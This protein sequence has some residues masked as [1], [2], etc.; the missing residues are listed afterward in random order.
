MRSRILKILFILFVLLVIAT[1]T[2]QVILWTDLPQ[3]LVIETLNKELGFKITTGSLRTSLRGKTIIKDFALS[4]PM[5]DSPLL[6][7]PEMSILHTALPL[8]L[9]RRSLNLQS[10]K[11]E[12]PIVNFRE[13]ETGYWNIQEF[14]Y[15][16]QQFVAGSNKQNKVRFPQLDIV[17]GSSVIADRSGHIE[18]L[19]P[20][21]FSG[22]T[23]DQPIWDFEMTIPSQVTVSGKVDAGN[24]WAHDIEFNIKDVNDLFKN[25]IVNSPK[26]L[27][28][29]GRWRGRKHESGLIGKLQLKQLHYGSTQTQGILGIDMSSTGFLISFEDLLVRGL[30]LPIQEIKIT[31]GSA[32]LERKELQVNHLLFKTDG[33]SGNLTGQWGWKKGEGT[34]RGSWAGKITERNIYSEGTWDG[35]ISWPLMGRKE[36][37]VSVFSQGDTPWGGWHNELTILGSGST[38]SKSNWQVSVPHLSWQRKGT[39]ITF[40]DVRAEIAADWPNVRLLSIES[41]NPENLKAEGEFWVDKCTWAI[42]VEAEGWKTSERQDLTIDLRLVASG[43]KQDV[44]VKEFKLAKKDLTIEAA[45]KV[46]LSSAKLYD[47]H[48]KASWMVHQP[49]ADGK[50]LAGISGKLQ[51]EAAIAGTVWPISLQLK[52]ELLGENI[53][54][55]RNVVSTIKIPWQAQIDPARIEFNT[56]R[57]ELFDG[58]W[59]VS[60]QYELYQSS[61]KLTLDATEVSL[62]PMVKLLGLPIKS[63]GVMAVKIEAELPFIDMND[64]TLTG[65]WS[66]KD[67]VLGAI[68]A[69]NAEGDV[70]I[71]HGAAMF[72]LI[73]LK[74]DQGQVL[75][76]ARFELDQPQY[77][78]VEM[79]ARQWPLDLPDYGM[80]FVTSSKGNATLDLLRRT[81]KGNGHITAV[82][83]L[84]NKKFGDIS[85]EIAVE[86]RTIEINKIQLETL[87]GSVGATARIPVDDWL[88]S[89]ADVKWQDLDI[90][91]LSDLRAELKGLS[92]RSSGI[93]TV[94]RAEENQSLEPLRIEIRANI[95]EGNFRNAHLGDLQISGYLGKERLL[96]DRSELEIMNGVLKSRGSI[97]RHR[98]ELLSYVHADFSQLELDQ[99]IGL[100]QHHPDPVPGRLTGDGMLIVFSDLHGMTGEANV[101]LSESDLASIVIVE[102]LHDALNIRL[103]QTQP[104]GQ[105]QIRMRFEGSTVRIPSFTYFNRGIEIR[106]MGTVQDITQGKTSPVRGYV[107]GSV[108]PLK[109]THLPGMEALDRLM[110]SLQTGVSSVEVKG[111]LGEPETVSVPFHQISNKLR[112]LLWRQLS[113]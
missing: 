71:Q 94:A 92:G 2:T 16:L 106:G 23:Q 27:S 48:A 101:R 63:Q 86:E 104:T 112:T 6:L 38:L 52:S 80:T 50:N 110:A 98:K 17:N 3:R 81:T 46:A 108:R 70:C 111:T 100:F 107:I 72:D 35:F 13:D 61:A 24:T 33:I 32:L 30:E 39:D 43:N 36:I 57:F 97:K 102:T 47:A 49:P 66:V 42:S 19:G 21:F 105:G 82:I 77:V 64:V 56:D 26:T 34:L 12:N 90:G 31:G 40:E 55:N 28:V 93:L 96:I 54:I 7:I 113:K 85:A 11:I 79:E 15:M 5:E 45:G 68:E 10:L 8:A 99:L 58:N 75:A 78:S 1:V 53:T 44:T 73:K 91:A 87:G 88:T 18:K 9:F 29:G 83:E 76:S 65:N 41:S 20:I 59:N 22:R 37:S 95:S 25:L 109:D 60:G 89:S 69:E 67:M 51:C 4:L 14:A 62:K 103:G 84:D 74:R